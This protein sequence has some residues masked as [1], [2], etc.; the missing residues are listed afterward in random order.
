[1]GIDLK[2]DLSRFQIITMVPY[3]DLGDKWISRKMR[4]FDNKMEGKKWNVWQTALRIVQAYGRSIRSKHDWAITY[5][6]DSNFKWLVRKNASL[7][8]TWFLAAIKFKQKYT[9]PIRLF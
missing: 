7:F 6:L 9:Y 8:P 5:I 4:S 1:M 3:P 2:D